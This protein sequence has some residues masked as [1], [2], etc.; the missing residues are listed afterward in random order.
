MFLLLLEGFIEVS[1]GEEMSESD[2]SI[3]KSE[4]LFPEVGEKEEVVGSDKEESQEK[5][6]SD[7]SLSLNSSNLKEQEAEGSREEAAVP[8]PSEWENIDV[9]IIFIP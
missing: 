6:S 3:T 2:N 1:D 4:Q 5:E 9:V 7:G 8:A